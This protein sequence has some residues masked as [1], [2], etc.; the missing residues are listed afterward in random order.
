M[1][2]EIA[3]N[4]YYEAY[5]DDEINRMYWVMKGKWKKLADIPDYR[6][7]NME[8]LSHLRPGFT[9]LIDIRDME[10]PG[11]EV[12]GLITEMTRE[13][14][15]AGMKRQA[16]IINKDF[17]E[18]IRKSR[19][20]IKESGMDLKMMQFGSSEEAIEWLNR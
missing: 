17:L 13:V 2:K 20:V 7:H 14:E 3:K 16:Q 8:T 9:A 10:I 12:L 6:K 19:D 4:E 11:D 1:K 18:G 5:V 15:N